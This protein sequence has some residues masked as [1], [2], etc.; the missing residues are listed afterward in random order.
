MTRHDILHDAKSELCQKLS[1]RDDFPGTP[2][3]GNISEII[4]ATTSKK[5]FFELTFKVQL[6][7]IYC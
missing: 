1:S 2:L 4:D 6:I 5:C 3:I 7:D